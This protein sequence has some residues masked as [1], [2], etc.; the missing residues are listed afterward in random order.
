MINFRDTKIILQ[1]PEGIQIELASNSI[2][3]V[4][5]KRIISELNNLSFNIFKQANNNNMYSFHGYSAEAK[6]INL[7]GSIYA[8]SEPEAFQAQALLNRALLPY[9]PFK[10]IFIGKNKKRYINCLTESIN[11]KTSVRMIDFN[12]T[13]TALSHYW[14]EE[15]G[16]AMSLAGLNN[17]FE[18]AKEFTQ[19]G[20]IFGEHLQAQLK[21]IYNDGDL[22]SD[23]T[24]E[25]VATGKVVN[26]SLERVNSFYK[27]DIIETMQKGDTIKIFTQNGNKR[28][29]LIRNGTTENIYHK[30]HYKSR[31]FKLEKGDNA[32]RY[33]AQQGKENLNVTIFFEKRYLSLWS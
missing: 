11:Y 10:L 12:I 14:L 8:N 29:D 3:H 9:Q 26:P 33:N 5:M 7:T 24:F 6:N 15:D 27:I 16:N 22:S 2:Y 25:L 32:I 1:N 4:D 30:M 28:V 21:N 23:V 13:I 17:E 19:N 20:V 31:F 18:F